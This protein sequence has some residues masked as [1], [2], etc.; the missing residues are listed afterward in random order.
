MFARRQEAI[1]IKQSIKA[2]EKTFQVYTTPIGEGTFS[3][4]YKI[5]NQSDKTN[6]AAKII[7]RDEEVPGTNQT[8]GEYEAHLMS[9]FGNEHKNLVKCHDNFDL[10]ELFDESP[11]IL[12]L[13]YIVGDKILNKLV[14]N[15]GNQST[16][17]AMTSSRHH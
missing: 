3:T 8:I 7:L 5:T 1:K 17:S 11:K 15:Y 10:G 6:F 13:D 9:I 16:S 12:I 2:L 14:K 4:V